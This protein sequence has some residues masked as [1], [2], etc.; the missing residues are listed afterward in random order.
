MSLY[1]RS[2]A[3]RS[4]IDTVA[5]RAV[6]QIATILG[7]VVMVRGMSKLDFGTFN[8]LYAFI[9]VI[10]TV[11]S[12]GL[13]QTL[14]RYQ[15]EYLQAGNR[16]AANWL[17][18]FVASAR[19]GTNVILLSA[20]LLGWN[21]AAPLFKLGPYRAEFAFFC[22]LVLLYFQ[23]RILQ[24]SL[25]AHMLHRYSVGSIAV[26]SVVKLVAYSVL[27]WQDA[28]TIQNAILA[29]T[30]AF[31]IAYAFLHG[32]YRRHCLEGGQAANYRPDAIER[33]RLMRYGIYNNFNDAGTM[34][35]TTKTDNFFIA[36]IID[37]ISVGIYAFYT[38]LREMASNL[39]PANLFENVVQP[40]FFSV[41]AEQADRKVPQYFSLL[42]NL[43]LM[44]QWPILA[45]TTAYHTQ[46]VQVVFGGKFI[47]HS[48][49]LP[50]MVGFATI[51]VIATPV[52]LVA[53][54]EE[55][56]GIILISKV[57]GIYNVVALLAL[58]PI[59]G[60]Y[61]AAIA[62]GSAQAMKNGFIWWN[63][64]RRA[65][66]TNAGAALLVS[67]GLWAIVV[68]ACRALDL[69]LQGKSIVSLGVGAI[70]V[71]AAGLL[72]VR[73]PAFSADDRRILSGV[74]RGKEAAWLRRIGLL[75]HERSGLD[76]QSGQ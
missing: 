22:L 70:V 42:L 58:L 9:P 12:L 11:A 1:T 47:E 2:R 56:A 39:L 21:Y 13:E 64:R 28:L 53:Q 45:Y 71:A 72:H 19:F 30:A 57:F 31:G 18:R 49:L 50:V 36:A 63:V 73:G 75:R 41:P 46:I 55:K 25:A 34:M 60:V 4:L 74:F 20:I 61:G 15:P 10:S 43:N 6:S 59:M 40:V 37:P 67:L 65:R 33:R 68:A 14:R 24:I 51:N 26:L 17:V 69:M 32:A 66:W 38:R 44:L 8:L 54:Q 16:A 5:F 76:A 23:S 27:V 52:T 35:L 3:R 48:W 7:Y 29:E 62:S